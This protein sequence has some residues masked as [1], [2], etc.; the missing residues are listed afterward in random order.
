MGLLKLLINDPLAFVLLVI[1][2]LFSVIIHEVAHG[3]VAYRMGDPTA[4]WLGRLTLNPLKHL[5]PIGTL[6][7]FLVGFGW[8]RPVP[9]NFSNISDRR[10]GLVFVSSAGIVANILFALFALLFLRLFSTPSLEIVPILVYY[11]VQ[12]NITL[13]ALNLIPIPPLDGSKIVM[14]IA[15]QTTQYFLARLEPYGFFIIIGL[16][17]LGILDPLIGFFRWIIVTLIGILLP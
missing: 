4:K 5:D 16:L 1:P 12:I 6:M 11:V 7:L 13:A 8:A 3:W 15:S 2:L 17:Y 14:G 10:K 9:V